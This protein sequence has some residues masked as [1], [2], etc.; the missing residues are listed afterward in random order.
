MQAHRVQIVLDPVVV[1]IVEVVQGG[2]R[3]IAEI[4]IGPPRQEQREL[5][6]KPYA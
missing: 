4:A 1:E 5:Q 2:R 6:Q 3:E